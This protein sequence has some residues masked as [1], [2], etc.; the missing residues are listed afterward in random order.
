VLD[1]N[2]KRHEKCQQLAENEMFLFIE[3]IMWVGS[4]HTCDNRSLHSRCD[5]V[6]EHPSQL[7]SNLV[8]HSI[9]CKTCT[10][11]YSK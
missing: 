2:G 6:S 7:R 10:S 4:K 8:S 11:E 3:S 5:R 9:Y 1:E